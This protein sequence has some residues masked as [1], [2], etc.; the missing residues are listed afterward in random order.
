MLIVSGV[1]TF[2]PAKQQ[3][4]IALTVPLVEATLAEPGNVTY[5]FWFDGS[6][7]GRAR[8]YEE[9]ESAEA[10]AEHFATPHMAAFMEG[11]GGVG[12][13]GVEIHQHVV[14]ESTKLM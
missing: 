12:V 14:S 1:L 6:E 9:W 7:P 5:G 3:E 4:F 11:M 2:D 10:I 8:A 13:T